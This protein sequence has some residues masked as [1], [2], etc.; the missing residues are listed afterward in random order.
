[1]LRP[2]HATQFWFLISEIISGLLCV[3]LWMGIWLLSKWM[4]QMQWWF[5]GCTCD[6]DD[7]DVQELTLAA[8]FGPDF[9]SVRSSIRNGNRLWCEEFI[10][11]CIYSIPLNSH[12]YSISS[13]RTTMDHFPCANILYCFRPLSEGSRPH[14]NLKCTMRRGG[15]GGGG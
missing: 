14:I 11:S 8:F 4:Q 5:S 15:R 1:M 9:P 2:K 13:G 7:D 6:D 10:Q 3:I 12:V